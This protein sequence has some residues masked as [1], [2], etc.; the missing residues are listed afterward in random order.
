MKNKRMNN[1]N[2]L[3]KGKIWKTKNISEGI[4][5]RRNFKFPISEYFHCKSC[6]YQKMEEKYKKWLEIKKS[7]VKWDSTEVE[8]P[9]VSVFKYTQEEIANALHLVFSGR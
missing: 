4:D 5:R 1:L 8:Y 3:C 2:N 9:K 7:F 6:N